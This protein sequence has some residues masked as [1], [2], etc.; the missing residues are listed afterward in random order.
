[1]RDTLPMLGSPYKFGLSIF[2]QN[3]QF[4]E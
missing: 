3:Q 1:M 2:Y 4:I